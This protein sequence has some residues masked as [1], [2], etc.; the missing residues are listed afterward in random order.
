MLSLII[1]NIYFWETNFQMLSCFV[2]FLF[3]AE[4]GFHTLDTVKNDV[5]QDV[6]NLMFFQSLTGSV[7]ILKFTINALNSL[8]N[9]HPTWLIAVSF[10]SKTQLAS[11]ETN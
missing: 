2:S 7:I 8:L 10:I 6:K 5:M 11:F 3:L 4:L 9:S 1:Q